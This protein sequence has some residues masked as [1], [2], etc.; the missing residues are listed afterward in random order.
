[1]SFTIDSVVLYPYSIPLTKPFRISAGEIR[2]KNGLIVEVRSGDL[3]GWGEAAVDQVPFYAHETVGSVIDVLKN[4][5]IPL[6]Q[7]KSFQHPDEVT[8]LM[9]HYRGNNF[10]KAPIDAAAWDIFGKL[11]GQPCWRLLGGTR[12]EVEIGPSLGIK[13]T[14]ELL[15]KNVEAVLAKGYRRIKVKIAPGFDTEYLEAVRKEFPN[16]TLMVDANNA[17]QE[18]DFDRIADWDRFQLLMIEQPLDEKDIYYHSLLRKR[19][20][21]PVCLDESIHTMHDAKCCV[22]L[23]SADIINIKVCRVGGLTNARRIHDFCQANG[24]KNWIGSR[25]GFGVSTA[26]RLV[27]ASLSNCTLPSDCSTSQYTPDDILVEPIKVKGCK[28]FESEK[29]GLGIDVDRKKLAKYSITRLP[30]C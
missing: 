12:S 10:A 27:A 8:D 2:E 23:G 24:I 16:I 6:V 14:P 30:I 18:S 9:A 15:L 13:D 1:M 7:H 28:A 26:P 25:I 4:A 17:Y 19:I 29:A 3:T 20:K 22:S 5:L 21:T 11:Q